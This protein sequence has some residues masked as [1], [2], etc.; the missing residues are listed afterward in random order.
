[1]ISDT[2]LSIAQMELNDR[3][4]EMDRS[5]AML[6][7]TTASDLSGEKWNDYDKDGVPYWEKRDD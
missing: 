5:Y 7:A 3:Q 1:M 6:A 4:R 2:C